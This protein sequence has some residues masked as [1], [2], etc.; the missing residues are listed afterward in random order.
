MS[1]KSFK[2]E[3]ILGLK[4]DGYPLLPECTTRPQSLVDQGDGHCA[5]C[6]HF[7]G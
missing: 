5:A 2:N 1:S 7:P 3:F 4:K 6:I